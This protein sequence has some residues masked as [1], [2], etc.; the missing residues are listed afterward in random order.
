MRHAAHAILPAL[1]IAAVTVLLALGKLTTT[2][3]L[4]VMLAVA[5]VGAAVVKS[6]DKGGT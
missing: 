5:G 3:A 6:A 1:V 4:P 2:E